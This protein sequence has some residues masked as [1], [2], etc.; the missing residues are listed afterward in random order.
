MNGRDTYVDVEAKNERAQEVLSLLQ[1][2][3][4]LGVLR[5]LEQ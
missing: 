3:D 1:C 2:A 4:I 5:S